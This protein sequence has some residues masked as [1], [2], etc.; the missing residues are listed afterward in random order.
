MASWTGIRKK[1]FGMDPVSTRPIRLK[2]LVFLILLAFVAVGIRITYFA[3]DPGQNSVSSPT[4]N[5]KKV[6]NRGDILDR[7]GVLLASNLPAYSI[8][9]HPKEIDKDK[10]DDFLDALEAIDPPIHFDRD[11]EKQK[12]LSDKNFAWIH[13]RISPDQSQKVNQITIK[14]IYTGEREV[15][16]YPNGRL[17]A[18]VLGGTSFGE[19]HVNKAEIIGVAGVEKYFNNLLNNNDS[20]RTDLELSIDIRAQQILTE[21]LCLGIDEFNALGGSAILMNVHTGEIISLVSIPDFDPNRRDEFITTDTKGTDDNKCINDSKN[22]DDGKKLDPLFN[23]VTQGIYELG[24]TFKIFSAAMALDKNHYQRDSI[25][26]TRPIEIMGKQFKDYRDHHEMT[27]MEAVARSKNTAAIRMALVI[28]NQAQ[29]KFLM[30][31]GFDKKSD[32]QL[33]ESSSPLVPSEKNWNNLT[34]ATVSFGHGMSITPLHLASAY[35][36]LVNGG[37]KVYPTLLRANGVEQGERVISPNTSK[38]VVSLLLNVVENGTARDSRIEGYLVGGKTGTSEKVGA[39][40]KY[41]ED[42]N[43]VIFASVFSGNKPNYSLVVMLD[44]AST[45]DG[46]DYER[47][48]GHTVVPLTG[49]IIARLGPVLDVVPENQSPESNILASK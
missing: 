9:A 1:Y 26:S 15:R 40:G 2:F 7:N 33:H 43:F 22:T 20:S 32:V 46:S 11:R 13:K 6:F 28:G 18:H 16:V 39:G 49:E 3:I 35:A 19:E 45:G 12:L 42:R 21:M 4:N 27:V 29:R 38:D 44:E 36:I 17:A 5:L 24:S 30:D 31:L 34:L 41:I 14:G 8:Y 25:I 48:A 23:M 47:Q 37:Y 10:V